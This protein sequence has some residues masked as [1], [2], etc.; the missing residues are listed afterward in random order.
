VQIDTHDL[1]SSRALAQRLGVGSSAIS[2]WRVRH[3]DF[4][5]PVYEDVGLNGATNG[6]HTV[7]FLWPEV[8]AWLR[9]TGR[10]TGGR[11]PRIR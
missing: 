5:Q 2:M 4:P 11:K 1:I 7:L 8:E 6:N 10:R 3:R 9:D